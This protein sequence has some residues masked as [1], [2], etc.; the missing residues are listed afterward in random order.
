[1]AAK[2]KIIIQ[3]LG[4]DAPTAR[5]AAELCSYLPKLAP[6]TAEALLPLG[7]I[8]ANSPAAIV[9]GTAEHLA[10]L[11]LGRLPSASGLRDAL[12]IVPK[13]GKLCLAGSNARS[14]LFAAY[15]LLEE[16]GVVFLRPGPGGEVL[17]R[18]SRLSLPKR[19]IREEASYRNRGICIE[20]YPRLEHVLDLLDWMAKKKMN[21]FQLQFRHAGVFWRRGYRES[22]EM[23]ASIRAKALSEDNN[24][25]LDDRVIARMRELGMML[26]RVGHGWTAMALGYA[27]IDWNETPTHTLPASKRD[28]LALVK[29]KRA[30]WRDEPTNTELCYSNDAAR[31]A[32]IQSVMTYA[33][34]HSEV[35]CLHVWMSDAINNR[36]ECNA[37]R[38]HGPSDWYIM[39]IE[40]IARRVKEEGLPTRIVFLAYFDLLWPPEKTPITADNV[41]FQYA[42]M[43][44]CY[45]HAL[46]DPKC[47]V[48]SDLSRPKLNESPR[49]GGNR[50]AAAVVRMWKKLELPDS[51]LFDYQG[52]EAIWRDGLGQDIGRSMAQDMKD[53]ASLGLDGL[54]SCQCVRAFYPLPY[55]P[56]TMADTLWNRRTAPAAHRRKIMSAAFGKY[57]APAEK[58]F[59]QMVRAFR[60]GADHEHRT[61]LEDAGAKHRA[62]LEKIAPFAEQSARGF[63]SLA[64]R[65]KDPVVR[66]SLRLLAVHAEQAARIARIHLAGLDGDRKALK[67]MRADYEARLPRILGD[68]S[69]W[70]DPKIAE[71]VREALWRAESLAG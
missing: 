32:F 19:P 59:A 27:G 23:P 38:K 26:H 12:A 55:F 3:P 1:M 60:V 70:I 65:E 63:S 37:C 34:Q 7:S 67:K 61:V 14:V 52:W 24:I 5:A 2:A 50:G 16:L 6:V 36:C 21:A 58:Y 17:P 10:G 71:P 4:F 51:F 49:L 64:K 39:I 25:A 35:D 44:R 66:T 30:F 31:E 18:K 43:G 20:G 28:W 33:R 8:P 29:G 41:V 47:D 13:N 48:E 68:F 42:P 40:E 45:R 22:A 53:L 54:I 9:L 56:S 62:R 15:R 46:S 69:P 11:G 57:A